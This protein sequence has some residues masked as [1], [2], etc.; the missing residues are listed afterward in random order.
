M[1]ASFPAPASVIYA[2]CTALCWF[3]C[4]QGAAPLGSHLNAQG[5]TQITA[6]K[7]RQPK[8]PGHAFTTEQ[9]DAALRPLTQVGVHAGLWDGSPGGGAC[10][11]VRWQPTDRPHRG[12]MHSEH[13]ALHFAVSAF[14]GG[15]RRRKYNLALGYHVLKLFFT[16][17]LLTKI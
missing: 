14:R 15:N 4:S 6:L 1:L 3:S 5:L 17:D 13:A 9:L 8:D 16:F 10:K 7:L 2:Q 12:S 11:A